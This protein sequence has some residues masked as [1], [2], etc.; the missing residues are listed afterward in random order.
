MSNRTTGLIIALIAIT[1]LLLVIAMAPK[2]TIAPSYPQQIIRPTPTPFAQTTLTFS[3]TPLTIASPSGSID[4]AID[5]GANN[6]TAVQLEL[7]YDPSTL[8]NIKITPG[9][10]F[11]NPVI[12]PITKIDKTKGTISY[13]LA[14]PPAG[15][16]RKGQGRIVTISFSTLMK[17]GQQT[18]IGFL[19]KTLVTASGATQSVLK[20]S[21]DAAILYSPS[22]PTIQ[23]PSQ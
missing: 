2:Q 23:L 21:N 16:A 4:V 7:S 15:T 20:T 8:T 1:A 22:Q 17:A 19:P 12:F 14:I 9:D 13:A 5:T 11:E 3:P 10:F 6:V 18:Q